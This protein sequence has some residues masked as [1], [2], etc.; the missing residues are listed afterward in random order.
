LIRKNIPVFL[1]NGRLS[2]RSAGRWKFFKPLAQSMLGEISGLFV[3]SEL[4]GR[5]FFQL[6]APVSRIRVTGNTKY[7]NL[8]VN[9][10]DASQSARST[11]FGKSDGLYVIAG[12]TWPGEETVFLRL[13]ADAS[14]V[15]F[16]LIVAPRRANRFDEVAGLLQKGAASWSRWSEVKK[17]AAWTTDILL[18]DTIGDLKNLYAAS[19]I[20]FVGGSLAVRGG[21]NPLEPAAAGIPVL[22]GPSMENFHEEAAELKRA[23]AA[24]QA[25]HEKDLLSDIREIASNDGT[26]KMM[27]EAAARFIR[28]K[29]GAAKRTVDGLG[30][31]LGL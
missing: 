31:L 30:E 13:L 4:D 16:R 25:R 8:P 20:A 5:R 17:G 26:R 6:G 2:A 24:R 11:L 19:D 7:D 22:F 27:G 10:G 28:G 12:S 23:G 3:R 21:Q 29:Q 9:S 14:P 18:V 15:R 1:V